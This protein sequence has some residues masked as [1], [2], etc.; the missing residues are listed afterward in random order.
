MFQK[1]IISIILIFSSLLTLTSCRTKSSDIA[2][3]GYDGI[4][5][6]YYK[7][8][9]DSDV[10]DKIISEYESSHKGLKINY[11]MFVDFDEY[12]DL[13]L[14]E[15]AEGEG[16][17]IFSMQNTWFA[18]NYKKVSPMPLTAGS[19]TDFGTLFVDV[20]SKDLVMKDNSTGLDKVFGLPLTVDTLALFYNKEQF[21][22]AIPSR[23]KPS[24]TWSGIV[25]DVQKLVKED[26]SFS[27]FDVAGI[28]MGRADN[29]NRAVDLFYL[30]MLQNGADFYDEEMGQ[31]TFASTKSSSGTKAALDAL[32]LYTSFADESQKN[33]SWNEFVVDSN[34][35][36]REIE[37]FARGDVSMIIGYSFTYEEIINQIDVLR[38]NGVNTID[39]SN[40]KV[41]PIPQVND[42]ETSKEKRVAY[43][44]YF[45]ESVSRNSKYPD[46]A[47]DFL[48]FMTT[49]ESLT[50]YFKEFKKP[51]SRRDMIEDQKNDP[52]YGVFVSQIG[53]AESFPIVDY[54]R[55]KEIF[56]NLIDSVVS[57]A[58]ANKALIIAQEEINKLM[59]EQSLTFRD[60]VIVPTE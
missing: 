25:E 45:A 9:D 38:S 12:M 3:E 58:T 5:L 36:L 52:I 26:N 6:T 50:T 2:A 19:P 30:L 60:P 35:S 13:I 39:K 56:T 16:P 10:M 28:A 31:A 11:R 40:V 27:R 32:D 15:M 18:S 23:G 34:S 17:D 51:T 57:G 7:M 54:Y 14:N 47:W 8:Y 42:P 20:A 59:P 29:I 48:V 4:E 1:K 24:T 41:A 46:L 53:Y 43:A 33:Y 37:A 49:K 22:D 21:E 55:Y 44:S